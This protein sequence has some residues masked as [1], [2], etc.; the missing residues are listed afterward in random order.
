[1]Y[2]RLRNSIVASAFAVAVFAGSA[3]AG[4]QDAWITTKAKLALLTTE[5]VSGTGINVDT[6]DNNVTLHGKVETEAE[7]QKAEAVVAKID[8][9]KAVNNVLQVVKPKDE[10]VVQVTDDKVKQE[11]SKALTADKSLS[12]SKVEVESVNNG[13]V[14]LGGTAN[15]LTD[16]L[17]AV[18][19]AITVPGVRR[20]VSEV[21][22]P[23][24][25][26]AGEISVEPSAQPKGS[27]S[28]TATDMYIT[29]TAKLRLL[30]DS[31]T[32]AL[33]INVD[34]TNG[35]VTLFGKVPTQE[36]KRAAEDDVRKVSGV[37]SVR[38]ELEVVPSQK[39]DV[40]EMKD[41]QVKERVETS[42]NARQEFKD[43]NVEVKNGVAR[44]SGTVPSITDRLEAA[45]I[46]RSTDGVRSV[47]EE[48]TV[49]SK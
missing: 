36:A 44:L 38:N 11:V 18:E 4:P 40:V 23:D 5:G 47:R 9:V 37:K 46:A 25:F 6:V 17:R 1:M 8:G 43:V 16:H 45:L 26:A 39:A 15:S 2:D 28:A 10:K 24:Q 7:K 19:V 48:L 21:K 3:Q 12:D 22:G 20:V 27:V 32:P 42:L 35:I 31:K 41:D 14:L 13:V 33:E 30:A 29:S 49:A 34:T